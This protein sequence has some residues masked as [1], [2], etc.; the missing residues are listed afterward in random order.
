MNRRILLL[1]AAALA[2]IA[3]W[4]APG[5]KFD[6][7][8]HDFGNIRADGG[9]VKVDYT[10]T[11]TGDE[12]LIIISVTNGGCGCTTPS[13]TKEPVGPG[14]KGK[15]TITFN[16]AGRKGE[17]NRQVKVRTNASSKRESL[18]FSGVVVP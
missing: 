12:P 17:F 8:K 5:I 11:N 18:R 16:P 13:F 7:A 2:A 4:A 6:S 9:P 1:A 3:A 14:A 15:V 10:F